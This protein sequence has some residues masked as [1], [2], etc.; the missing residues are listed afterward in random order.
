MIPFC[1]FVLG[2]F[3]GS[4]QMDLVPSVAVPK[5]SMPAVEDIQKELDGFLKM[6]NNLLVDPAADP[7]SLITG[8]LEEKEICEALKLTSS[9]DYW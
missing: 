6:Y 1:V 2:F 7:F 8:L 5:F 3:S 4:H 9:S